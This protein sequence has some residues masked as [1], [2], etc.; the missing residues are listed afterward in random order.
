MNEYTHQFFSFRSFLRNTSTIQ[1]YFNE[2]EI[3]ENFLFELIINYKNYLLNNFYKYHNNESAT[4]TMMFRKLEWLNYGQDFV[5]DSFH[6]VI[7]LKY[8]VGPRLKT[9]IT[10][11]YTKS[12]W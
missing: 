8:L 5:P 11:N 12:H 10:P 7:V 3:F 1:N 4:E 2:M 6:F 9:L